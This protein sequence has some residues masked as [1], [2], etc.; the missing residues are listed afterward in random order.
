MSDNMRLVTLIDFT[1]YMWRGSESQYVRVGLCAG[2][3]KFLDISSISNMYD[4]CS[5][6]IG[7][8]TRSN[9]FF[10]FFCTFH[11]DR[12]DNDNTERLSQN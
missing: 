6:E 5:G 12:I 11:A 4:L 3:I 7:R 9:S 1:R 2:I 8:T 10:F